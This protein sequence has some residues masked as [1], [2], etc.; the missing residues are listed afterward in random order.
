MEGP[1]GAGS[2]A[3]A[4]CSKV[5]PAGT[6]EEGSRLVPAGI[7]QVLSEAVMSWEESTQV[8]TFLKVP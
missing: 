4:S 6:E 8:V 5:V 1:L 3:V 7:V 2:K